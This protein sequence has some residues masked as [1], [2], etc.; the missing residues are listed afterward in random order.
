MLIDISP[1]PFSPPIGSL[2]EAEVLGTKGTFRVIQ[3]HR[4]AETGKV[5]IRETG[6]HLRKGYEPFVTEWPIEKVYVI[7]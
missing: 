5:W 3:G 4:A 2:V 6:L 1:A 7:A